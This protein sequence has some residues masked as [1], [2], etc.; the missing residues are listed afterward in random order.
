MPEQQG[1]LLLGN[2]LLIPE[3]SQARI[4]PGR[5]KLRLSKTSLTAG[6]HYFSSYPWAHLS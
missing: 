5:A 6:I 3:Q 4:A 1:S 2:T